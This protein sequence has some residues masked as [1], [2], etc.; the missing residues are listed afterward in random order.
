MY[1]RQASVVIVKPAGT[2]MPSCVISASPTPLPPRSS[3]P[4]SERSSKSKTYLA[5]VKGGIFPHGG[6]HAPGHGGT[7]DRRDRRVGRRARELP[8]RPHR[9]GASPAALG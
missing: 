7:A 6:W 8:A 2:G 9:I 5:A 1:A 3:R 4:P